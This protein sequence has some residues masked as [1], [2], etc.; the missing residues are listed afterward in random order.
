MNM[1]DQ[2]VCHYIE[3]QQLIGRYGQAFD[4]F[5]A[6][7]FVE[8]FAPE[9][10]LV[11]NGVV[12]RGRESI[13]QVVKK[14]FD[15]YRLKGLLPTHLAIN[16][17]VDIREDM[18][19]HSCQLMVVLSRADRSGLEV[20]SVGKYTDKLS[21]VDGEWKFLERAASSNVDWYDSNED[22]FSVSTFEQH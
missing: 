8:L 22:T 10:I 21:F 3:I 6:D 2:S 12:H 1:S 19:N 18:A 15:L 13:H 14:F 11:L 4:S 20:V 5:D 9:G 17:V 7:R 16:S